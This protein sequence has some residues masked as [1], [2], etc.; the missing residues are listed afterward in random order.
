MAH[1][2]MNSLDAA[3][4]D[5]DRAL[6]LDPLNPFTMTERATT[7]LRAGDTLGARAGLESALA[8][9]D[10]P[11]LRSLL[12]FTIAGIKGDAEDGD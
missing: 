5:F 10:D 2:S 1:G 11:Q 3:F 6:A 8:L 9:A 4:V 12:E 7:L